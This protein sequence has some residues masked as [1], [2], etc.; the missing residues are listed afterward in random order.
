[1]VGV[2]GA[3]DLAEVAELFAI[4]NRLPVSRTG[5]AAEWAVKHLLARALPARSGCRLPHHDSQLCFGVQ[6][7]DYVNL[8]ILPAHERGDLR[9]LEL[10]R[11]LKA[12]K[13]T[14]PTTLTGEPRGL[15]SS[16]RGL[17]PGAVPAS[18]GGPFPEIIE[19]SDGH[20]KPTCALLARFGPLGIAAIRMG[21][22]VRGS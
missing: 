12:D 6:V 8:E 19:S 7:A 2:G 20:V 4:S 18:F 5:R 11:E 1:M 14:A 22:S 17:F 16:C 3:A 13:P 9:C 10:V 15:L 21:T